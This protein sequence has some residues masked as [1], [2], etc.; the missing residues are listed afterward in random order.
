MNQMI[1]G[2][3]RQDLTAEF[4]KVN[5]PYQITDWV[6]QDIRNRIARSESQV[7]AMNLYYKG[8][9]C[10]VFSDGVSSKFKYDSRGNK[11]YIYAPSII[12]AQIVR[13]KPLPNGDTPSLGPI[14]IGEMRP[15][16]LQKQY[17]PS[18]HVYEKIKLKSNFPY[19]NLASFSDLEARGV[20][21][22]S[23]VVLL[24]APYSDDSILVDTS[25]FNIGTMNKTFIP[26][27]TEIPHVGL[28]NDAISS[29]IGKNFIV[30]SPLMEAGYTPSG[31]NS[32]LD[33]NYMM[34]NFWSKTMNTPVLEEFDDNGIIFDIN[35]LPHLYV[36]TPKLDSS[37][38]NVQYMTVLLEGYVSKTIPHFD[39]IYPSV[40][41]DSMDGYI[42]SIDSAK[43]RVS[44]FFDK[45][46]GSKINGISDYESYIAGLCEGKNKRYLPYTYTVPFTPAYIGFNENNRYSML[47]TRALANI[48][49][50][51]TGEYTHNMPIVY[52][53]SAYFVGYKK[54]QEIAAY[55]QKLGYD[56]D[57]GIQTIGEVYGI[58][59]SIV[60]KLCRM[61]PD[62]IPDREDPNIPVFKPT[63]FF[64]P[65][66]LVSVFT[67]MRRNAYL[68]KP[69]Y[70]DTSKIFTF[71]PPNIGVFHEISSTIPYLNKP[72]FF[73]T[74]SSLN[75]PVPP[76]LTSYGD[77]GDSNVGQ[78]DSLL[79]HPKYS[80]APH[81][82]Y[83]KSED[84]YS[85]YITLFKTSAN[86][87]NRF[88][89]SSSRQINMMEAYLLSS[90]LASSVLTSNNYF[91]SEDRDYMIS[92]S[93]MIALFVGDILCSIKSVTQMK[94][95]VDIATM[96]KVIERTVGGGGGQQGVDSTKDC[97][98]SSS[99]YYT[100]IESNET[101]EV[102]LDIK[103]LIINEDGA[104][105]GE[106][107]VS[108]TEVIGNPALSQRVSTTTRYGGADYVAVVKS[109]T[110][111]IAPIINQY[112]AGRLYS[113]TVDVSDIGAMVASLNNAEQGDFLLDYL[114]GIS[115][116]SGGQRLN[117]TV[118]AYG[119]YE[120]SFLK[121][122]TPLIEFAAPYTNILIGNNSGNIP[123]KGRRTNIEE[124]KS[125]NIRVGMWRPL[126][127]TQDATVASLEY[128]GVDAS[129]A[130]VFSTYGPMVLVYKIDNV[131]YYDNIGI[132]VTVATEEI[133]GENYRVLKTDS[134]RLLVGKAIVV[135]APTHRKFTRDYCDDWISPFVT[136]GHTALNNG[137]ISPLLLGGGENSN[138][139]SIINIPTKIEHN[140]GCEEAISTE[141]KSGIDPLKVENISDLYS[142]DPNAP[143]Q[144]IGDVPGA[145][146]FKLSFK[147]TKYAPKVISGELISDVETTRFE[148]CYV[149]GVID[150]VQDGS[151][152]VLAQGYTQD[153][154]P[155]TNAD[156]LLVYM[157]P[158]QLTTEYMDFER[159]TVG[160]YECSKYT[161]RISDLVLEKLTIS[162][163]GELFSKYF[164]VLTSMWANSEDASFTDKNSKQEES[165]P[166]REILLGDIR[167]PGLTFSYK[168]AG[169]DPITPIVTGYSGSTEV[170]FVNGS[171]L[172]STVPTPI[173]MTT[174]TGEDT[175]EGEIETLDLSVNTVHFFINNRT[176]EVIAR[177]TKAMFSENRT[178]KIMMEDR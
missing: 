127:S 119:V 4:F 123:A 116:T 31:D 136:F 24:D 33:V 59:L 44:D 15:V 141:V 36:S 107:I 7:E 103:G 41:G 173:P 81:L 156:D 102:L 3:P 74:K 21:K 16:L 1:Y 140:G 78:S 85:P 137:S 75:S 9:K 148:L 60:G 172:V 48:L 150:G 121:E 47:N 35:E 106:C 167:T 115:T 151:G 168:H 175:S 26:K 145:Y 82:E 66:S 159:I 161:L 51:T 138:I 65:P 147:A 63:A 114:S 88:T 8:K 34:T 154:V 132:D 118:A 67:E 62:V 28:S 97:V 89:L 120:D 18:S 58:L 29:F 94:M 144:K 39:T 166:Y 56:M 165:T 49:Y 68:Q 2:L 69:I 104:E 122:R 157:G 92:K 105:D 64:L 100:A 96:F 6:F 174:Y 90:I 87:D 73:D 84:E 146:T 178:I 109:I 37:P 53:A 91:L 12:T 169:Q 42:T 77:S 160:S 125:G 142:L 32:A 22:S 19:S 164:D 30:E 177:D 130:A 25:L 61:T 162:D 52:S 152:D 155:A 80:P 124:P 70:I 14:N 5:Q 139:S 79:H 113:P 163:T 176:I 108:N 101:K 126:F 143:E 110:D 72:S 134:A 76:Y 83:F 153:E 40:V 131:T 13:K 11:L 57:V 111:V 133:F 27:K 17:L 149:L 46:R 45:I 158:H 129:S 117:P 95:S 43:V 98:G 10:S 171:R 55:A 71:Q 20:S 38:S 99:A 128:L 170:D 93:R 112:L 54:L 23:T 50:N 86:C 135:T